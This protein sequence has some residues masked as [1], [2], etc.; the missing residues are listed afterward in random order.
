MK[1]ADLTDGDWYRLRF[2][3]FN[4]ESVI[5]M[6]A[7]RWPAKAGYWFFVNA[8]EDRIGHEGMLTCDEKGELFYDDRPLGETVAIMEAEQ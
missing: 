5:I 7:Y 3:D 6:R 2:K 4:R 1:Y 8:L